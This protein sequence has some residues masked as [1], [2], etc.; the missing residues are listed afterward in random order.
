MQPTTNFYK[1]FI[2]IIP[3]GHITFKGI[4]YLIAILLFII[5][6]FNTVMTIGIQNVNFKYLIFIILNIL[7]IV[8]RLRI[9]RYFILKKSYQNISYNFYKTKVKYID[10]SVNKIEKEIDYRDIKEI[11]LKQTFLQEIFNLGDITISTNSQANSY[12][13]IKL[14]DIKNPKQEYIDIKT[15]I[16]HERDEKAKIEENLLLNLNPKFIFIHQLINKTVNIFLTYLIL[17]LILLSYGLLD[18]IKE[19]PIL[20]VIIVLIMIF[21]YT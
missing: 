21:I 3:N 6:F 16:Q 15:I 4:K 11:S 8:L 5:A 10:L 9:K 1:E 7:L 2:N 14:I 17:G 20:G 12:N 19:I 18:I 13:E